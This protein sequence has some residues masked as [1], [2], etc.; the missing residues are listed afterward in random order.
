[1]KNRWIDKLFL[2]GNQVTNVN[3]AFFVGMIFT[4]IF[5]LTLRLFVPG[6]YISIRKMCEWI[7]G[8]PDLPVSGAG[9]SESGNDRK[10]VPK[11]AASEMHKDYIRTAKSRGT[12][13]GAS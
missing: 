7:F 1:M 4:V 12:D 2:I 10:D 11:R 8:I 13:R 3:P 5:G 6:G 9:A